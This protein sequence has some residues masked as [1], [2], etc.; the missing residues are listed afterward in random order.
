M[1]SEERETGERGATTREP[2]AS[3]IVSESD[4][5][6]ARDRMGLAVVPTK[7]LAIRKPCLSHRW[8]LSRL[9]CVACGARI[10]VEVRIS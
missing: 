7:A 3:P 2:S 9:A 6:S 10:Y 8:D 5:S 4:H 1:S